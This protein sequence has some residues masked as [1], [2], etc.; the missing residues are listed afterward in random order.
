LDH[1]GLA[2]FKSLERPI[3]PGFLP[4][5]D[6]IFLFPTRKEVAEMNQRRLDQLA[7]LCFHYDSLDD[8]CG[9]KDRRIFKEFPVDGKIDLK[10]GAQVMLLQNLGDGLANGSTGRVVGFY[11]SGQVDR[12][13]TG[14][15][16]GLLRHIRVDD[17]DYPADCYITSRA[18]LL[19]VKD[20]FPLV[21]FTTSDGPEC[22]LVMPNEFTIQIK[23]KVIARR[24]QVRRL[25]FITTSSHGLFSCL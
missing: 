14:R 5:I 6:S 8:L 2:F 21:K 17:N 25:I 4:H 11:K 3:N 9:N 19:D 13:Q 1:S 16:A 20:L 7:D 18:Q 15:R 23:G 10:I 22:V 24:L 12:H